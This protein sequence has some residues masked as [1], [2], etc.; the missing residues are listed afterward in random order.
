[1]LS[2]NVALASTNSKKGKEKKYTLA[3]FSFIWAMVF[4]CGSTE[5]L[6]ALLNRA[7]GERRGSAFRNVCFEYCHFFGLYIRA[8]ASLGTFSAP[9]WLWLPLWLY[10]C[11]DCTCIYGWRRGHVLPKLKESCIC[12]AQFRKHH[13]SEFLEP[14]RVFPGA[15]LL[16]K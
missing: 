9:C 3:C 14:A 2:H 7:C 16:T 15:I 1:M 11:A 10:S 13:T 8:R 4:L 12:I 6:T 5:I